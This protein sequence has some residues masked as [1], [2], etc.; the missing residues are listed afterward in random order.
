MCYDAAMT[1]EELLTELPERMRAQ[2]RGYQAALAERLGVSKQFVNQLVAGR[3]AIGLDHLQPIL[4]SLGLKLAV[5]P[6]DQ[7]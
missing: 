5:V 4:D 3:S 2:P 7:P 1:V 6:K